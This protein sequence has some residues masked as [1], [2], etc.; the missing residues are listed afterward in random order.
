MTRPETDQTVERRSTQVGSDKC[1]EVPLLISVADAAHLT[2]LSPRTV[3]R[4][5]SSGRFPLPL[6]LGGR[7]LFD[8]AAL[9]R[10]VQSGCPRIER[11]HR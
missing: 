5:V 9:V 10:W 1:Q 7:R 6:R 2:G 11:D 4:Y 3:W 8:R